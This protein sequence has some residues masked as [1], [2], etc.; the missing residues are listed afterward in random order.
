MVPTLVQLR[1]LQRRS[2]H[3][4]LVPAAHRRP[5]EHDSSEAGRLVEG[6]TGRAATR[7][8]GERRGHADVRQPV[9]RA[10]G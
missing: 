9:V 1:R 6:E 3:R 7:A 10:L 4:L 5:S 2:A 8:A